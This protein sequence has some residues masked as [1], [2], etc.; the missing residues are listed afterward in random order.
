MA[1]SVGGLARLESPAADGDE[2]NPTCSP[3]KWGRGRREQGM[4]VLAAGKGDGRG[5]RAS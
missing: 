3:H 4:A 1:R 2:G 5:A